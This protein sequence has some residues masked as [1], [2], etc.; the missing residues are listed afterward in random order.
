[1]DALITIIHSP[2]LV[3]IVLL[4]L[5]FDFLNGMH[6]AANS[7]ATIVSTRVLSPRFA[8]LWAAFFN[9]TAYFLVGTAVAKTMGKGIVSPDLISNSVIASALIG[10]SLWNYLT[11]RLGLPVSSS[12]SLIGGL[13]GAGIAK[14][15]FNVV[16]WAGV[17]KVAIFIVLSPTIGLLLGFTMMVITLWIVRHKT[18]RRVDGIFRVL[19]LFSSAAYSVGHGANDAQKTAG[20]IT[21]LLVVNGHLAKD[22]LIPGPIVFLCYI[23]IAIGTMAGGWRIVK[24]L[25]MKMTHIQPIGGFCAETAA[26]ITLHGVSHFG[27]PVSTTHT[28]TGAIVGVGAV[29]G[30]R[31]VRWGVAGSIVWAWIFTIPCSAFVAAIAWWIARH[32]F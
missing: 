24:T 13:L 11:I 1:M 2:L 21:T 8:V 17:K 16:I 25:G 9:F 10:A 19:Q 4:A 29:R 15:G 3:G 26:A 31:A 5:L 23:V 6:D 18:P 14:A 30:V 12:H 27:I 28:I 7:I 22:A 32:V 20:I